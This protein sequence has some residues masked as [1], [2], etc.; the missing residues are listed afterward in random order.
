MDEEL[1]ELLY[2]LARSLRG[3]ME[4]DRC[5]LAEIAD[6]GDDGVPC[7]IQALG[8]S[9]PVI[10]KMAAFALG[11]MRSP[12]DAPPDPNL[13]LAVPHLEHV[14][15]SDPDPKV[16]M[17]AAEALWF[18]CESRAAIHTFIRGL[19]DG[20]VEIRRW[21]A[22]M[23]GLHGA[24]V[25]EAISPLIQALSDSDLLVRRIA[26]EVLGMFGPDAAIALP[27][28]EPF[29]Q[30]DEWTRVVAAQAILTIDP[31]RTDELF[32]IL[33]EAT[34]SRSSRIRYLAVEA[35]A[36]LPSA[37]K[38]AIPELIAALD[39]ENEAVR[40]AALGAIPNFGIAAS[41]AIPTLLSIL[42]GEGRDGED[43]LARGRAADAL[44]EIGEGATETAYFLIESLSEPGDH[45]LAI[46]F[47]LR[48]ARAL[49]R[50]QQDSGYLLEIGLRTIRNPS[51]WLRRMAAI[52]LGDLGAAGRVAIP[53]LRRLIQDD[54][55]VV[56]DAA[57]KALEKI[58]A[59]A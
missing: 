25:E 34:A 39:D 55:P 54:N 4:N 23:L 28:V 30:E 11:E 53:H 31:A 6:L 41:L 26:A 13:T 37:G 49:W 7:L 38:T 5:P 47:R 27:Q 21:A 44:A 19:S 1:I 29:L 35:L 43:L 46:S 32:P 56:R 52:F 59:V 17:Q 12:L 57:Q 48:V 15:A 36:K 10:R 8:H 3:P 33:V 51:V 22:V 58:E 16:R 9:D 50:I 40:M 18:L 2:D 20:D 14:L 24:Q 45:P 42:R